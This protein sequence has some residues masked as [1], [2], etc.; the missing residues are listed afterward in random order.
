MGRV[1][2]VVIGCKNLPKVSIPPVVPVNALLI[3][4]L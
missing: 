1:T 2:L 4:A 3:S